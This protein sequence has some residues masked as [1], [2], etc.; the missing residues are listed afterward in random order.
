MRTLL[1]AL[2]FLPCVAF[3]APKPAS[4]AAKGMQMD[5]G[6]FMSYSLLKPRTAEE[7]SPREKRKNGD[8]TP[9]WRAGDLLA[10]KGISVK[11]GKEAGICFDMDT[12]RYAAGWSGGFVDV[13]QTNLTRDQGPWPLIA[14]GKLV[15]TTE[16]GPGW[17]GKKTT[18]KD[19][20]RPNS[21]T[22]LTSGEGPLPRDWAHYRGLYRDG[23]KVVFEYTVGDVNI[24][25]MPGVVTDGKHTALTRTISIARSASD[26]TLLASSDTF[27]ALGD[28]QGK[29]LS[30][31]NGDTVECIG[32]ASVSGNATCSAIA[33]GGSSGGI[34][35]QQPATDKPARFTV[36]IARLLKTDESS[37][38][39]LLQAA[40]KA[41]DPSAHTKGGP[42]LWNEVIETTGTLAPDTAPYVIDTI[43]LPDKN[44]WKSWM[45]LGGLD[46]F[47]DGRAAV[48]TLNGDVWIVSGLSGKLNR[49]KWKRFATGLYEPLGL[50]IVDNQI[51]V[52]DRSGIVKLH[53]LNN[54]GEADFYENFNSDLVSDANYHS[55]HYDLQTDREGNFYYAVTGNQMPLA[56]PDHSCVVKVSKYGD[57]AEVLCTGLRA[58][59]GL[60]IGPND[61]LTV[62]DNQGHWVPASPIY[63]CKPG[64]FFGYHGD[65]R[66]VS[67]AEFAQH[68]KDHPK[69][70]EPICWVPYK[71]DNSAAGQ[72][73]AGKNWGPFSGHMLHLSYGMS[74]IFAVLPETVDGAM[75]AGVVRIPGKFD[76]GLMRA[77]VNPVDGQI[78]VCGLRGWQTNAAHDG[79]LQRLRFTG[80]QSYLPT[81]LHVTTKGIRVTFP[82]DL[83]PAAAS[84]AEGYSFEVWGFKVSEKYGSDD[85]KVSDPN[86]KGRDQLDVKKATLSP[87]KRSVLIDVDGL[88]PVTQYILKM[89]L[90]AADGTAIQADIGG[91]IHKLG[92]NG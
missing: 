40:E 50:R 15:F 6:P 90:K 58:A 52:L 27:G 51:Y 65:E 8:P 19:P 7:E 10:T 91:S 66:R 81:E 25:D 84:D 88:K 61:E 12:C 26:L 21:D 13:S 48:C 60:G 74:C 57:K 29:Y 23:D 64:A 56:K 2:V 83:D 85:Y 92:T 3:A 43:P 22:R 18:H 38:T 79:C 80:K 68:L 28:G 11:L 30:V 47:P 35:I 73:W 20:R 39:D 86:V 70:D 87:D 55:F 71:W 59:N 69:N 75:Q 62:G 54:D 53:D 37:F 42:A 72:V 67:S 17:W 76:S 16:D 9:L 45:K 34:Y 46:F 44:P 77:R 63:L 4:E 89:R 32:L 1:I 78:W 5:Y 14:K 24:L 82:V 33:S 31:T 41:Q 49:V 36:V